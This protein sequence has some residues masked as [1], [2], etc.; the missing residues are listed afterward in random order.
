MIR[1]CG[2]K[3]SMIGVSVRVDPRFVKLFMSQCLGYF[4]Q[5]GTCVQKNLGK[6]CE[7]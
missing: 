6:T 7:I 3:P 2:E 1:V 5:T 4:V